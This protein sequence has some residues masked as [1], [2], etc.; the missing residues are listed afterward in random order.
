MFVQK[1]E[2]PT[3]MVRIKDNAI[4]LT[5]VKK[6]DMVFKQ[7]HDIVIE[8]YLED[9]IIS[10]Q[11]LLVPLTEQEVLQLDHRQAVR[12]QLMVRL[13]DG[14]PHISGILEMTVGELLKEGGLM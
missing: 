11:L 12:L 6:I 4:D 2:A 3:L 8:K 5:E 9:C 13:A 7:R 14:T 1:G 10:G